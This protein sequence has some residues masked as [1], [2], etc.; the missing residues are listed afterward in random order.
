MV[1]SHRSPDRPIPATNTGD[2]THCVC[3]QFYCLYSIIVPGHKARTSEAL[4]E[5]ADRQ[6]R[7]QKVRLIISDCRRRSPAD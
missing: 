7:E 2:L 3:L 1:I 5:G 6:R 4:T